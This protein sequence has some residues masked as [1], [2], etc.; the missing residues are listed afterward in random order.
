MEFDRAKEELKA[1]LPEYAAEVLTQSRGKNQYNC[2]FCGSGTGAKGT[3]ALTI[4][5]ETSRYK[6][7]SCGANGDIFDLAA[8]VEWLETGKVFKF[9]A[10]KY[11][12]AVDYRKPTNS[13]NIHNE[14]THN[15]YTTDIHTQYTQTGNTQNIHKSNTQTTDTS[16]KHNSNTDYTEFYREANKHLAETDYHRGITL[17]TLNRFLVGYAAEWQPPRVPNAPKTPRLIIPRSR[18]SYFARDTRAAKDIP[19]Y[20]KQYT[21]QNSPGKISLFNIAAL[22]TSTKPLYIVEG[23]IDAMSIID[24]GGEAIA[25]CST[26]NIHSFLQA[27]KNAISEQAAV[28][29]LIIAFDD[30]ESG[31]KATPE[32]VKGLKELQQAYCIYRPHTG[33][34]DANEALN[35]DRKVFQNYVQ[36]G[37]DH[38]NE[39]TA[40]E[41]D[42]EKTEYIEKNSV[43]AH[44]RNFLDGVAASVNTEAIATG[45]KTLDTLLD[46][47]LYEGLYG[48]G[49]ISSLGK[50]TFALQIADQIAAV[51]NDV[52]IFSLEMSRN[53]MIAKSL[54]RITAKITIDNCGDIRNAK[55][56]RGIMTGK[57][58]AGYSQAEKQLIKAAVQE[59]SQ[60][61]DHIF[62][63]EAMGTVGPDQIRE[64]VE[65]HISFTGRKPVVIIDYLQILAPHNERSTDK[66]NTDYAILQMKRLSRDH[67]IPVIVISSFNRENY[68]V[69][70]AMQ[71][72]KESGAIEYSTDVLI[73]LQ[74]KGTGEKDFDV[75][76]AKA[77]H[78]RAIEAVILKNRNGVTGKKIAYN[79]YTMFNYFSEGGIV[80]PETIEN[81]YVKIKSHKRKVNGGGKDET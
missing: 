33:Y 2:P 51:G 18:T 10:E 47:G 23:E 65:N 43:A 77:K 30:D 13:G 44:L 79:Y 54:S 70:V 61:A 52:L 14:Y 42:R 8:Q 64:Q 6:C 11:G 37:I 62:I 81:G 38:I 31:Q 78:P 57:K 53:E 7:F 69:K 58:Y 66:Q 24:V 68:S 73:G 36:Y 71:A 32:L 20:Q 80:E 55:T 75:D 50:T 41:A 25:T 5:P 15:T 46:G 19:A 16:N 27:L 3:G 40:A 17:E 34:K 48:I 60:S 9:L 29:P 74:L 35:A 39:L 76:E 67:K 12:L 1:K 59:Y 4:Y 21:K 63:V 22:R 56:T 28:M 26:S 72:F 45:F 49:A